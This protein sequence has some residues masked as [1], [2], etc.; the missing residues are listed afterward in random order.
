MAW[1]VVIAGGGFGGAAAAR[2]LERVMP[3]QSARLALVNETNFMLYTPFLPEAAA[4][5]LEPRHVVTPLRD[6]LKRTYLR[7][8]SIVGHDPE[9]KTVRL[10]AKYGEVETLPYDQLL[11]A[12][13]SVSRTLPVPGLAEHAIG[14]KGLADA[15]W[16]RNHVVETLEEANATEDP[17]RRDKLLTYVFVGGGYAGLEALAELQDFAADAMESYPRARL[18]GMRWVLVEASD[19]VLPEIDIELADYALREL[20]GRGIDIRL[21]TTLEQV[22]ADSARLSSGETLPTC[23]VVWTAG[24]A[25]QPVLRDLELPLDE[26]G[27]VPVD[28]YLKVEGMDS[29]WAIGDCASA[30]DPRGGTCPPT[31]QHAVR[32]GPV[33]ARNIA[34]E[35]GV[36]A[37]EAFEYRSEASFV[38]LGRYKAVGRIGD[39]TF[40]GFPAWWLARTYHMSQIPGTARKVRAVLDWTAGLP[41]RRDISEVGSIGHPKRLG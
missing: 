27:R 19:R 21:G 14:F 6:I 22:E 1:N 20:R 2:E 9:A 5:T 39:R 11:L 12:L 33:V 4:G 17:A 28:E 35:L 13:G 36:G 32:Q 18:H 8:G 30:P 25:P 16:L 37:P 31:A 38:N 40:R 41:F 3:R 10:R 7:L 26:R 34:A 15:I 23:T 29:V 24:V